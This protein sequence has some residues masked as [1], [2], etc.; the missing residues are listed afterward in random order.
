[1]HDLA[2]TEA[3]LRAFLD[4]VDMQVNVHNTH[5]GVGLIDF[6]PH[7]VVVDKSRLR[8]LN[9]APNIALMSHCSEAGHKRVAQR[10]QS[11]HS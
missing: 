4:L 9:Y 7:G 8:R 11:H 10:S 3:E 1:M 2:V 5:S 6:P